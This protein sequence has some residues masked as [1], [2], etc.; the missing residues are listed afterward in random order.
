MSESLT[1]ALSYRLAIADGR[2]VQ[3]A[4]LQTARNLRQST[5]N[6][7]QYA[8]LGAFINAKPEERL[9]I[10]AGIEQMYLLDGKA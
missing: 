6:E 2:N 3:T 7:R 5:K 1:L 10:A 8:T 4:I 9:T